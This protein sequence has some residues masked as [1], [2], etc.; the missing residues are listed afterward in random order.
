MDAKLGVMV[1]VVAL[2][3]MGSGANAQH[4][5]S[6]HTYGRHLS[7]IFGQAFGYV[8]R[9]ISHYQSWGGA[10]GSYSRPANNWLCA[11]LLTSTGIVSAQAYTCADVR[12]LSPEQQAYYIRVLNITPDQQER[13]RREC[14]GPKASTGHFG[15]RQR[16]ASADR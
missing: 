5:T 8:Q 9:Q 16:D 1:S 15:R 3:L 10:Y 13:I 4:R 6:G 2:V 12:A 14:Y 7:H 11:A